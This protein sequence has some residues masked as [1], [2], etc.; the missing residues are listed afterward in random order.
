MRAVA[1]W[2]AVLLVG[3]IAVAVAQNADPGRQIFVARC[4]GCHG[5]DG[6]GGE[7][8]PN[9]AVRVPSRTDR[10]LADVIHDGLP[11]AGMPAFAA[12]AGSD[13]TELIRFLR[14][15]RA[16]DGAGPTPAKLALSSGG[17]V[18]GLVLNQ[19]ATDVQLLGNDRRIHLLRKDG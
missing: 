8:G 15:L 1:L 9:I 14:T 4:A 17:T 16:S 13:A 12:I 10:E 2:L 7:Q 11:A 5:T 19:S 3:S 18:E 6:N